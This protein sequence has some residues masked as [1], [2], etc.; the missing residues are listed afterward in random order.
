MPLLPPLQLL[1]MLPLPLPVGLCLGFVL[2]RPL[3]CMTCLPLLQIPFPLLIDY[4]PRAPYAQHMFQPF[5]KQGWGGR[6]FVLA[7][8]YVREGCP[9]NMPRWL[10][11]VFDSILRHELFPYSNGIALI[12]SPLQ[13]NV[14]STSFVRSNV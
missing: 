7:T 8:T 4:H 14:P 1:D 13:N 3:G 9:D 11:V 2:S 6:E 10:S 12:S 5:W